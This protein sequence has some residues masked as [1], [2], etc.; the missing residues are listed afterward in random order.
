[1][2]NNSASYMLGSDHVLLRVQ[3]NA[4]VAGVAALALCAV[5]AFVSP[6][7]FFRSYLVAYLFWFGIAMG[8]QAILMIYHITGG[9]W[10]AVIR[11]SLESATRTFPLLAV[12]FVPIAVG[13]GSLYE[14]A[15]PQRVAQDPLLQH[16]AP[17][18]NVPFFLGRAVFYFAVWL[19]L[20]RLLN[21]WSL[22]QDK[23]KDSRPLDKME[24]ISRGGLVAIG[25]TVTF[26]AVDWAMSLEPHWFSTLY[27]VLIVGGQLLSAMAFMIVIAA[28]LSSSGP[29]SNVIQKS[30]FHD[31]G[32]LMFAYVMLWAYF[33]LSQL[34]IIW[35]A[36]LT[37]E[38]PWYLRRTTGGWQYVVVVEVLFHFVLPFM[39]LLSRDIKRN[40]RRLATVAVALI[41]ACFFDVF[42]MV[43]PAFHPEHF[44]VHWLDLTAVLGVGGVWL[45]FFVQ[46]LKHHPLIAVNDPSLP[47]PEHAHAH[48]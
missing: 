45:W 42:W 31:L 35:S 48:A 5:G 10:G 36:N 41:V 28:A 39:I 15:D 19:I 43:T 37:E 40:P 27:G 9:A 23:T 30:Q 22:E 21:Y 2:S 1:M 14:W 34:I 12:L 29:L 17:Y 6:Q 18:L 38:I 25:L 8:S 46:Q 7:Q 16:K 47:E 33:E 20:S 24:V 3:R 11:R 26:A 4:L 44:A 13:V 32:K